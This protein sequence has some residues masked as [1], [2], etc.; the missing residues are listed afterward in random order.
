MRFV[1]EPCVC[2]ANETFWKFLLG[3]VLLAHVVFLLDG[4]I[5]GIH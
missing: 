1:L 4:L 5:A 3:H 2:K